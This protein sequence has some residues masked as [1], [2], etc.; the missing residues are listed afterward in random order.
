MALHRDDPLPLHHQLERELRDAIRSGRLAAETAVPSTRVLAEQLGLSRGVIVEAYEQLI[1]EGYLAARPGGAT[2]SAPGPPSCRPRRPARPPRP[3][4]GSTSTT[5]GPT[6]RS[7]RG[8]RGCGRSAACSTRRPATGSATSTSA[9]RPSFARR[10][11]C[12]LNRVRGTAASADRTV[13]TNG[14][15][16]GMAIVTEVVAATGGRRIAIEDP[17]QRDAVRAARAHGLEPVAVPVDEA[18]IV[19]EALER[20]DVDAVV[21]TPAHQFPTGAVMSAERRAALVAWATAGHRIVLEDDYDAEYRYDREPIGALQGLAPEHVIY[22]GS[23]SKTLAPGLR[24]GWLVAPQRLVEPIAMAKDASDRGSASLEQLAFAD[25]LSRGDFDHHLRRMRPIYRS[26]RDALLAALRRHAP[27]LRPVGAS[28]G[29]H[30]VAWLPDGL[31]EVAV[32]QRIAAAGVA[33]DGV[34]PYYLARRDGPGGLL[35]GYGTLTERDIEAA[36]RLVARAIR[37][38]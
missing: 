25:F 17:G 28:A 29:L 14:F 32:I 31:D 22:A 13:I 24:L 27:D 4:P 37:A 34:S 5:G 19:V 18:G 35:F 12:Y 9:A 36:I 7:S 1:A 2:G 21:V 10:L 26:R 3:R 20:A 11:P 33:V 30:V 23:A 8:R 6:S 15:A 16:Q 38:G